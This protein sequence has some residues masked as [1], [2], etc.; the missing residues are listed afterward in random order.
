ME[1]A[2]VDW[3][4]ATQCPQEFWVG[5]VPVDLDE[6]GDL[7]S[8]ISGGDLERVPD[9]GVLE[10]DAPPGSRMD[11]RLRAGWRRGTLSFF[12]GLDCCLDRSFGVK[13][14][15]CVHGKVKE[16]RGSRGERSQRGRTGGGG[17][18]RY[19]VS[20]GHWFTVRANDIVREV[21]EGRRNGK[22][23]GEGLGLD[24]PVIV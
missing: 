14:N 12:L 13:L 3:A 16:G 23:R 5:R 17:E 2:G 7:A 10:V 8:S 21:R 9:T 11:I 4:R 20:W 6:G 22:R 15:Q 18:G 19:G 1:G 24:F